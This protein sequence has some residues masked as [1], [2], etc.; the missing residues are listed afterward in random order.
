MLLMAW[1]VQG[2]SMPMLAMP[3][4]PRSTLLSLLSVSSLEQLSMPLASESPSHSEALDT[5]STSAHIFATIT[6][7]TLAISFSPVSCLDPA[8]VSS[9]PRKAPL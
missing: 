4:I 8:Q 3:R 6:P 7:K 5:V 1:E 9:G 2:K